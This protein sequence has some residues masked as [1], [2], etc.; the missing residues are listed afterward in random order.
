M[1]EPMNGERPAPPD[2]AAWSRAMQ[3]P[4]LIARLR[5]SIEAKLRG[6]Q[7][8]PATELMAYL[9]GKHAGD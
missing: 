9:R 6:E 1:T 5:K 2:E 4:E 8:I 7:P 3:N